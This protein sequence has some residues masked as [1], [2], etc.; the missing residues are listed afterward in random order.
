MPATLTRYSVPLDSPVAITKEALADSVIMVVFTPLLL[1]A[2]SSTVQ[3]RGTE[4]V[5]GAYRKMRMISHTIFFG[6]T[7][8]VIETDQKRHWCIP[9]GSIAQFTRGFTPDS[10]QV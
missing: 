1:P 10:S 9:E 2:L 4:V 8:V 5:L 6:C 3:K 7:V